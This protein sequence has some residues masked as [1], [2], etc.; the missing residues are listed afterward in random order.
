MWGFI[1]RGLIGSCKKFL[2]G[3]I[4]YTRVLQNWKAVLLLP[5]VYLGFVDDFWFQFNRYLDIEK[6]L[7]STYFFI[8]YK[9]RAGNKV[10][11]QNA[12]LR[13][14][15]YDINDLRELL[16]YLINEGNEIGVH[17][18][19]AWHNA[20]SG[21]QE[22]KRIS[23]VINKSNLGIRTHWLLHDN[24]T[25]KTL[26]K[27]GYLWDSSF[28]YNETIGYR[29]GN[30]QVFRPIGVRNLLELPMHIQDTALFFPRRMGLS[31]PDAWKLCENIIQNSLLYGGVLTIL[32][33]Q[34]SLASE[35]LWGDFYI[36]LI[37]ET[38][39]HK[40]WFSTGEK[41]TKWFKKRR[42]LMF[43]DVQLRGNSFQLKL[44]GVEYDSLP[45]LIIR[46]H[47]PKNKR[48]K[49]KVTSHPSRDYVDVSWDGENENNISF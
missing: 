29:G 21:Y 28:G 34:R 12:S 46:V 2:N 49:H 15:K 11:R 41:V 39:K 27:A 42:S 14:A 47:Y 37:E 33:H 19:D 43:E 38:K 24:Q 23:E 20:E 16:N 30:T 6:N 45:S 7:K 8:P 22:R 25:F 5:F 35:R 10:S 48:L 31:E 36:K 13:A 1:Y 18:I 17:G 44:S 3:E 9:N 32:W 4:S 26:E 40:V